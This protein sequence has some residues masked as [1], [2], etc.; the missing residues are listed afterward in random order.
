[1][2]ISIKCELTL[3]IAWVYRHGGGLRTALSCRTVSHVIT[4]PV[5]GRSDSLVR[6]M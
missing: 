1:M 2:D 6:R 4:G 5:V 3:I